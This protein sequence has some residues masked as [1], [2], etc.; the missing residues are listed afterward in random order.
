MPNLQN[1]YIY[2]NFYKSKKNPSTDQKIFYRFEI[3]FG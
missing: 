2:I 1:S 3:I